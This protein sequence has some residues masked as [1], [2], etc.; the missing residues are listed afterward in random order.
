MVG[1]QD[2]WRTRLIQ[3]SEGMQIL[4]AVGA[5]W[6]IAKQL[7]ESCFTLHADDDGHAPGPQVVMQDE[8]GRQIERIIVHA[9]IDGR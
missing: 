7:G 9:D 1:K 4:E 2:F 6:P 3:Q 5:C 8:S